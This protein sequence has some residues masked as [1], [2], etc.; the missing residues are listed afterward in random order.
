MDEKKERNSC[1]KA[2]RLILKGVSPQTILQWIGRSPTWLFKWRK[3]FDQFG[4]E[5]LRSQPRSPII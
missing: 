4:W 3:R 1:R 5:G 2:I